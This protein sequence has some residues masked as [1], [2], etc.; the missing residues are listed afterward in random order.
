M[1]REKLLMKV[2]GMPRLA[3]VLK[4]T[5]HFTV[6]FSVILYALLVYKTF[7]FRILTGILTL[8]VSAVGFFAVTA[9]RALI[10]APRPYEVYSIF[11]APPKNR[12]G[13]SFPGRH[14]FSAFLV[15]TLAFPL[16]PVLAIVGLVLGVLLSVSRVLLGIHFVRDVVC[17]AVLGIISGAVGILTAGIPFL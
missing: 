1:Q 4:L 16:Y 7:S 2:Q 14:A 10:N 17:G 3:A 6:L 15:A 8:L 13:K 11:P 12:K 5:S 9:A